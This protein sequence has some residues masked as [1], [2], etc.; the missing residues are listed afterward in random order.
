MINRNPPGCTTPLRNP[1]RLAGRGG[2]EN[3]EVAS[4]TDWDILWPEAC[5]PGKNARQ[6]LPSHPPTPHFPRGNRGEK[7]GGRRV[8][9]QREGR[10][11][12]KK[13]RCAKRNPLLSRNGRGGRPV[14]SGPFEAGTRDARVAGLRAERLTMRGE[15][16]HPGKSGEGTAACE[17]RGRTQCIKR[18]AI[19]REA[20]R[21]GQMGR[22]HHGACG[23]RL[24]E[25]DLIQKRGFGIG[26][27]VERQDFRKRKTGRSSR[28]GSQGTSS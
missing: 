1:W 10:V 21:D 17:I 24:Q 25:G 4:P 13:K 14:S 8:P 19:F 16:Y 18:D 11:Q 6:C 20:K 15:S 22:F 3:Q 12:K 9:R 28:V 7:I 5:P 27:R 2:A 23:K 26:E